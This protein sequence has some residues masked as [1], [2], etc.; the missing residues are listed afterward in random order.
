MCRSCAEYPPHGRRC[1]GLANPVRRRQAQIRQRIGRYDRAVRAASE[2][3]DWAAVEK[4]VALLDRDVA[5]HSAVHTPPVDNT[6][7]GD[8]LGG[9]GLVAPD[10]MAGEYT[11]AATVDW[12]DDDLLTAWTELADDPAAQ[13]QIMATLE[14]REEVAA[15]RDADIAAHEQQQRAERERAWSVAADAEDAS[16]L[17]NPARRP[18]RRLSPD[19][20]CR[21][22]YDSFVRDSYVVAENDC[23]GVMLN[24][25]GI[26]SGI[27]PSSFFCGPAS[28]VRK[29]ASEELRTWFARNG[30]ITYGE[31]KYNW[32]GRDSDR[33]AAR[34]ARY[35]SLGEVT[36]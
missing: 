7:T 33:K 35:Q 19:Q 21:E 34:N 32:F 17:T 18:A 30:R 22:E 23:R 2:I 1:P 11:P 14:W 13:D 26:A 27:D 10:T 12:S 8:A 31:W 16:P 20:A 28:R 3:G 9:G 6:A 4:Y 5:Q 25:D 15:A 29:Y 36:L 24:R